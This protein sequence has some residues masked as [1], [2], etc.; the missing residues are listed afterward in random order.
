MRLLTNPFGEST[1]RLTCSWRPASESLRKDYQ[2]TGRAPKAGPGPL[3]HA[4]PSRGPTPRAG[5]RLRGVGGW[6]P[7]LGI[8]WSGGRLGGGCPEGGTK[9]GG[10]RHVPVRLRGR[11]SLCTSGRAGDEAARKQ[12]AVTTCGAPFDGA[13]RRTRRLETKREATRA[14]SRPGRVEWEEPRSSGGREER[15][16]GRGL[17]PPRLPGPGASP[18]SRAQRKPFPRAPFPASPSR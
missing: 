1:T 15:S 9:A 13:G 17:A 3:A 11:P 2:S 14:G 10:E 18:R 6:C 5:R 4:K 7:P 8:P 12:P 16:T